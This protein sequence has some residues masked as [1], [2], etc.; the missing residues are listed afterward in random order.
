MSVSL[1]VELVE[2]VIFDPAESCCCCCCC[3][4]DVAG[5]SMPR[6]SNLLLLLLPEGDCTK[7]DD[8]DDA[9]DDTD[10][11]AAA[12]AAAASETYLT[13]LFADEILT[14]LGFVLIVTKFMV[15]FMAV[16]ELRPSKPFPEEELPLEP[17][18]LAPSA[19]FCEL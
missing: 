14:R 2:P 15:F 16:V 3:F 13:S 10:F 12:A 8:G 11:V 17:L 18:L 4:G 7:L 6:F 19:I 9:V 5:V 1:F